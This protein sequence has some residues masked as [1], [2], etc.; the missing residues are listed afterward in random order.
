MDGDPN[1][2]PSALHDANPRLGSPSRRTRRSAPPSCG[3][4]TTP[5]ATPT[6]C[7]CTRCSSRSSIASRS[8]PS[9]RSPAPSPFSPAHCREVR[10]PWELGVKDTV[11][12]VPRRGHPDQGEVRQGRAIRVALPHRRARGQ[13]DDAAVPGRTG[14][15][16]PTHGPRRPQ[17]VAAFASLSSLGAAPATATSDIVPKS[18]GL[19]SLAMPKRS[20]HRRVS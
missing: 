7:T 14:T 5:P 12:R 3:S 18:Q 11:T 20:E 10:Q 8:P 6:P 15:T 16:R 9:T 4:S 2:A 19:W 13:R 1:E 17:H